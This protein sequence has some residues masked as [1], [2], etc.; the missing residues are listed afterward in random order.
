M[1]FYAVY[2]KNIADGVYETWDEAKKEIHKTAKY[3]K[4]AT[5]E[6]AEAFHKN[7]P[8]AVLEG[9]YDVAVY[10]DGACSKNGKRGAAAGYGV[11]FGPGDPRNESRAVDGAAQ[12]NNAAEL[13]AV[14]RAVEIL[15]PEL[16][17]GKKCAVF[18][19]SAYAMHCCGN[20][21]VKCAKKGWKEEIPNKALVQRAHAE[22]GSNP[23][24]FLV[25]V[26]AHTSKTDIHSVG[27]READALA[28]R[29]TSVTPTNLVH[30]FGNE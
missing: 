20:Y 10:T 4:F 22:V 5:R 17:Q 6:E 18:T 28:V 12:T 30:F 29:A 2:T 9:G 19:D 11:F 26:T 25:H 16:A 23:L 1:P 13:L 21:G 8:H 7:G 3:K 27:N 24:V 14:L 15:R